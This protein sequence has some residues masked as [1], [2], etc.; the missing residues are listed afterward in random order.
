MLGARGELTW[1]LRRLQGSA[2]ATQVLIKGRARLHL[3]LLTV[4]RI[5]GQQKPE[6]TEVCYHGNSFTLNQFGETE[7]PE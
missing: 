2:S 6:F 5:Q 4:C 3:A 1:G 7:N